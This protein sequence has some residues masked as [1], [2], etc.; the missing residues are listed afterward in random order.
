MAE[1]G[2]GVDALDEVVDG[3][4]HDHRIAGLRQVTRS[5]EHQQLGAGQPREV[6]AAGEGLA[7]VVRAVDDQDRAA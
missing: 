7:L 3:V 2:A 4:V 1:R 5:A 6:H